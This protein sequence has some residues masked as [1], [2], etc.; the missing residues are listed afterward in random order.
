MRQGFFDEGA[1]NVDNGVTAVLQCLD[2]FFLLEDD[3][4][5]SVDSRKRLTKIC[6]GILKLF[7]KCLDITFAK[8]LGS[9]NSMLVCG[10]YLPRLA[11]D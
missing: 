11:R 4:S 7:L 6:F 2:D 10:R 1:K 5:L 8:G 3:I 9:L